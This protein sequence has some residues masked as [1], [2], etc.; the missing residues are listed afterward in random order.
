M[1]KAARLAERERRRQAEFSVHARGMLEV[2]SIGKG[3]L[4]LTVDSSNPEER[5]KAKRLITEMLEK[6]Y[7]IYVET[8]KGLVRV[9]RFNPKRMTY[10]IIDEPPVETAAAAAPPAKAA[11]P[12]KAAGVER[13][14]PVAGSRATAV[15]RTAGG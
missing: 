4:K 2:L 7:G 11:K 10:V 3:D 5:E 1:G 9:K 15:G 14:V 6:G 13:E 12:R 8:D